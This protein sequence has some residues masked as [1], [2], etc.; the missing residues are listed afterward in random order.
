MRFLISPTRPIGNRLHHPPQAR[1]FK[2]ILARWLSVVS[3]LLHLSLEIELTCR[4]ERSKPVF[5]R[6]VA[7]RMSEFIYET[8][9]AKRVIH[10]CHGT[11][12]ADAN[13][14]LRRT[15]LGLEV[16]NVERHV[17]PAH[18]QLAIVTIDGLSVKC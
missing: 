12:P 17:D 7:R 18:R 1:R 8:L 11:E 10:V 6:V 16:R 9:H 2:G 13:V 14:R 5:N 4:S 15:V 3:E